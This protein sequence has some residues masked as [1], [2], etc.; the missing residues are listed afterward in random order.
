MTDRS[1]S[2]RSRPPLPTVM[3]TSAVAHGSKNP[4]MMPSELDTSTNAAEG[5]PPE[6]DRATMTRALRELEAARTRVDR[7]ARQVFDETRSKLVVEPCPSSTTWIARS[8]PASMTEM[9]RPSS[10]AFAG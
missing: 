6:P 2:Y 5:L 7:D 9:S 3:E 4:A 8:A 10:K 1:G